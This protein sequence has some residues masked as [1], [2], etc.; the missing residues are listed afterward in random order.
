MANIWTKG[1]KMPW[2]LCTNIDCPSK[3]KPAAPA[4]QSK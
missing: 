1:K 2:T 4:A 3:K